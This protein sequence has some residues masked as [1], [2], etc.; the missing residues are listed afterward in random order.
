MHIQRVFLFYYY[1][2]YDLNFFFKNLWGCVIQEGR[3]GVRFPNPPPPKKKKKKS[4]I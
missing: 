3:D 2:Y 4:C 1:Y